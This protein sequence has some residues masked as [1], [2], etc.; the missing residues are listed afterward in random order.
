MELEPK[1]KAAVKH[2]VK[3][4]ADHDY[5]GLVEFTKGVRLPKTEIE[6]A[7]DDYGCEVVMP[8]DYIFDELDVIE[9][10]GGSQNEWSVRLP[11]WTEEEGRS[12]LSVEL[13]VIDAGEKGL[14][15]ELDNIIV[16]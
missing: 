14:V 13:S 9:V 2:V 12:D 11:L 8:P 1:V 4:L 16:F 3:L 5:D 10:E 6:Y 7:I 15:V